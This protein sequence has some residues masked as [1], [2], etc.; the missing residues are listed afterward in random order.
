MARLSDETRMK[1]V[2]Q[3][4]IQMATHDL[5]DADP[6][7][8][9]AFKVLPHR[10]GE[11]RGLNALPTADPADVYFD[12]EGYPLVVG[13]LEYLF[14]ACFH[15]GGHLLFLIG[16]RIVGQKKRLRQNTVAVCPA[17]QRTPQPYPPLT[18]R[19]LPS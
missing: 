19:L 11:A 10:T 4:R 7:T 12:M 14:G 15:E 16:G 13:G 9:P 2:Q 8:P 6:D 18:G 3:A 5:R 17:I 1:L